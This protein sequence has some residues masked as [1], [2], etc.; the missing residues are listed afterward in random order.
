[1]AWLQLYD[2]KCITVLLSLCYCVTALLQLLVCKRIT[3][4]L[5]VCSGTCMAALL[6][7]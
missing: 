4:A 2:Y 5:Q 3:S 7:L 6:H 1:M